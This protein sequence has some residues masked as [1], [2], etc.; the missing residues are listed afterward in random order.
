M[1]EITYTQLSRKN[2]SGLNDI[3]YYKYAKEPWTII[4]SYFHGKHLEQ[5]VRHQIESYD[6]FVTYQIPKTISMF[7]PVHICSEKA[8]AEDASPNLDVYVTFNN[9]SIQRNSAFLFI[10]TYIWRK[11]FCNYIKRTSRR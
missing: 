10:G 2:M 3:D 7:N 5:M 8:N 9:F 1:Q 6:D 4:G 11:P